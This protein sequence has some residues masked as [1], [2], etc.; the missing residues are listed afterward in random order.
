ML[1]NYFVPSWIAPVTLLYFVRRFCKFLKELPVNVW[2]PGVYDLKL[3]Q[4]KAETI[5]ID[6]VRT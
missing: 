6:M 3:S 5:C 1:S 4:N 2:P